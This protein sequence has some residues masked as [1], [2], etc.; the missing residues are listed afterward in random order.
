M[1]PKVAIITVI[2]NN[3]TD[4]PQF[5]ETLKNV[6]YPR[7]SLT[8]HLYDNSSKDASVEV[9]KRFIPELPFTCNLI[10]A[11][12]NSGFTGGNNRVFETLGGI[13]YVFLLNPDTEIEPNCIELL[14]AEFERDDTL[15]AGQPLLMSLP[16]KSKINSTGNLCHFLGFGMVRDNGRD[17]NTLALNSPQEIV[18][19]SGA[20]FFLRKSVMAPGE[21]LFERSFFAYHEDFELSWRIR[22]KGYTLRLFPQCIVY[23]RYTFG[24]G[25][26]KYYLI[27]RNRAHVLLT[28]YS[29]KTLIILS[30]LILL[31]EFLIFGQSLFE[32]WM[33]EKVRAWRETIANIEKIRLSRNIIQSMRR[34]SDG[35]IF[36]KMHDA[37]IFPQQTPLLISLVYNPISKIYKKL[38]SP[39][40]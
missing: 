4:L 12:D 32:G 30:P 5:F 27:E 16:D 33:P 2:F 26:F 3:E 20:A 18:S 40:I 28:H 34:V 31:T 13:D 7:D 36:S 11:S 38:V 39:F 35:A 25:R 22:L 17:R 29:R 19:V 8:L 23:H 9:A 15:G 14:V 24:K 1:V 10:A 6:A 37:L 21:A